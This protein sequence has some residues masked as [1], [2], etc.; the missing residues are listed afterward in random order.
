[1]A[2][3]PQTKIVD[4]LIKAIVTLLPTLPD[5]GDKQSLNITLQ[6]FQM[7]IAPTAIY[8]KEVHEHATKQNIQI[9]NEQATEILLN[10]AFDIDSNYA[11][12][13]VEY[14]LNELIY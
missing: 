3:L 2:Y 6:A 13:A 8:M 11:D 7:A 1:M 5:S 12:K 10:S 14:H 9:T 4:D